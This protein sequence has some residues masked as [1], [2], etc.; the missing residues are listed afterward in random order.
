[1]STALHSGLVPGGI[2][3]ILQHLSVID[4]VVLVNKADDVL[5]NGVNI[6][7]FSISLLK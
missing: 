5:K 2:L 6:S 3:V 1:M 7:D 4:I